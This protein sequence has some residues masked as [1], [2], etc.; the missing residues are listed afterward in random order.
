[1][2]LSGER[3]K[4]G[5]RQEREEREREREREIQRDRQR[6]RERDPSID[7]LTQLTSLLGVPQQRLARAVLRLPDAAVE[8][9]VARVVGVGAVADA[10]RGVRQRDLQQ[11]RVAEVVANLVLQVAQRVVEAEVGNQDGEQES[12]L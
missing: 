3:Q 2:L 4:R 1:M 12:M 9:R 7:L 6:Q 11:V 8:E 10:V 5:E